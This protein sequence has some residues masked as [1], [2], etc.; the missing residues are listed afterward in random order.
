MT[1]KL[2]FRQQMKGFPLWQITILSLVRFGEPLAFS[3]FFPYVYFMLIDFGIDERDTWRYSS[4]YAASFAF[5]QFLL[6]IQWGKAADKFG[7]KPVLLLTLSG[8]S[9]ALLL[10]GFAPNFYVG[11]VARCIMGSFTVIPIIRTMVGEVAVERRHQIAF[12]IIPLFWN[13]GFVVG[14]AIGGS[15]YLTKTHSV[16]GPYS[17]YYE[18]FLNTHP[19]A[20]SNIVI[21]SYIWFTALMGFF[22]LKETH[23]VYK[24][25][26]DVG[27]EIGDAIRRAL[28]FALAGSGAGNRS[29]LGREQTDNGAASEST[30]LVAHVSAPPVAYHGPAADAASIAL[31]DDEA[32]EDDDYDNSLFLSRRTSNALA[33][34]FSEAAP[35]L[36]LTLVPSRASTGAISVYT[37]KDKAREGAFTKPVVQTI[38]ATFIISFH[39]IVYSEFIPVFLAGEFLPDQIKFPFI[40]KGGFGFDSNSIGNLLSI[41]GSVGVFTVLVLFPYIDRKLKP[42][43]SFRAGSFVYPIIYLAVP[44]TIFTLP[45]YNPFFHPGTTK[46]LLYVIG[47][48]SAISGSILFPQAFIMIHRASPP[49]HRAYIN[50]ASLSVSSLARCIAPLCWGS[51]MSLA[52]RHSVSGVSWY[53]LS[54]LSIVG[55]VQSFFLHDYNEDLKTIE[56]V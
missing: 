21:A 50:G 33:R 29:A 10:F 12:S 36:D 28:G 53:L 14:P 46:V 43:V 55:L 56:D 49:R 38:I 26:R 42:N 16:P 11:L 23:P 15:S 2:T 4:Y 1:N 8:T 41:T 47:S 3:S 37:I 32:I 51:I 34:R 30:P 5:C 6:A 20:L 9:L 31:Y 13:L 25:R 7:R 18:Q 17:S 45:G 39:N 19:F 40:I 44:F 52:D 22:F 27:I 48:L 35:P 54:L 24:D